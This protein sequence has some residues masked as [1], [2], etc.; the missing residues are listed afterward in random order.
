MDIRPLPP[1]PLENRGTV[2]V[3]Q[4]IGSCKITCIWK[5]KPYLLFVLL[6]LCSVIL[7]N[8]KLT[9]SE[10]DLSVMFTGQLYAV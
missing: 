6:L 5:R 7:E 3:C 1:P 9:W 2:I 4:D 8:W 10:F